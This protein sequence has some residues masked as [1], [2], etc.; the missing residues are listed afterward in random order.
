ML[1][2]QLQSPDMCMINCNPVYIYRIITIK[3]VNLLY[4][5]SVPMVEKHSN[6]LNSKEIA[7][8]KI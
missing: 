2:L 4:A 3:T 7:F 6:R 8:N 5:M 1:I